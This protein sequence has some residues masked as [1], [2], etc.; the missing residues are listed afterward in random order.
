MQLVRGFCDTLG[1]KARLEV[2][3]KQWH[4][5]PVILTDADLIFERRGAPSEDHTLKMTLET[6]GHF[7]P[8]MGKSDGSARAAGGS[9]H[10]TESAGI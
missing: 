10:V 8:G 1:K 3:L 9:G 5:P 6:V 4:T 7:C 2:S